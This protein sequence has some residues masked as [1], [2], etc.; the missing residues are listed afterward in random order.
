MKKT[1]TG[2]STDA[3]VLER[4]APKHE[5]ARADP[6]PSASSR[7]SSTP[8]P[9]C[10]APPSTPRRGACTR[11]SSRR[12][13]SRGGSSPPIPISS[14]RPCARRRA[15]ASARPSSRRSG[16][17]VN[18]V[19]PTGAR[20]SCA[21]WLTSRATRALIEAFRENLDVH[22]RDGEILF[23]RRPGG[24]H[25]RA[26]QRGQDRELR[27]HLR[28]GRDR[29]RPDPGHPAQGR[30]GYIEQYFEL[31]RRRAH[32]AR[33]HHRRGPRDGLR[34]TSSAAAATSP[35]SPAATRTDRPPASASPPTPP[36]RARPRTS[37]SW[38]CWRSTARWR[39][40][41]G[42]RMLLQVHDELVFEVPEAE[43]EAAWRW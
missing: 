22:R 12:R 17:W 28:P 36:S 34:D 25:A 37:A 19:A 18:G 40:A 35:S 14:A 33:S 10:C 39:V 1:K 5:I 16:H 3:E 38:P 31:L 9:T 4:L 15:S 23:S 42:T 7:S 13:A 8:T 32:L 24:G 26:A 6:A 30:Q 2:Y 11:P 21:C 20:S 43:V 41:P 27:H 29:A